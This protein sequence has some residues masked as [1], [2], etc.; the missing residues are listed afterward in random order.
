MRVKV[1][2][3]VRGAEIGS[4]HY[5]VLLKMNR[6]RRVERHRRLEEDVRIRTDRMKDRGVRLK[7]EMRLKQRISNIGQIAVSHREESIEE[8]WAEFKEGI[9]STT[10]KECGVRC[11]KG[12]RKKMRWWN[13]KVKGTV[14]K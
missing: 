13:E 4:D 8:V 14:K 11:N 2:K 6:K 3:V 10:V 12:Q 9:L 7:F 1:V 5:L